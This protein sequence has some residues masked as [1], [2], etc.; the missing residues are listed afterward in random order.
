VYKWGV[1]YWQH[2]NGNPLT[3]EVQWWMKKWQN[4]WLTFPGRGCILLAPFSICDEKGIQPIKIHTSYLKHS[5]LAQVQEE[6]QVGLVNPDSPGTVTVRRNKLLTYCGVDTRQKFAY[7]HTGW[8]TN[9]AL[10]CNLF[11]LESS[12]AVTSTNFMLPVS[13]PVASQMPPRL[14]IRHFHPVLLT[15]TSLQITSDIEYCL[16]TAAVVLVFS[17]NGTRWTS[18]CW[19]VKKLSVLSK[20]SAIVSTLYLH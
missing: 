12:V 5:L 14:C 6:N 3:S 4:Q 17:T 16:Y 18:N 19:C 10:Q 9:K 15:I 11:H 8:H 2:K 1:E 20:I 13:K 7:Q